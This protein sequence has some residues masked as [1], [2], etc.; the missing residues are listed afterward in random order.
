MSL[1]WKNAAVFQRS[2]MAWFD[3]DIDHEY[4]EGLRPEGESLRDRGHRYVKQI[5]DNHK[6][7]TDTATS[8]L[9][10]IHHAVTQGET[11]PRH[12][13]FTSAADSRHNHYSLSQRRKIM[14]PKTWAGKGVENIPL[15]QPIHA[16]QNYMV[17]DKVA[18]NIFHGSQKSPE[19][20]PDAVGDPDYHPEWGQFE[21]E[22]G[23]E[24]SPEERALEEHTRFVRRNDG[25]M[26]VAD[27]HHRVA[28][29]MVLGKSHTPG[30][31][32]DEE[33]LHR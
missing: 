30:K 16:T 23:G 27:G 8:A 22:S 1:L 18:H 33:E 7:D 14:D 31:V 19:A 15:D 9:K 24:S 3:Q 11:D 25:R 6:V 13:G 26:E 5:A 28:A 12:Y 2:G 10:A 21:D 17:P 20:E 32:I 29:D 4:E